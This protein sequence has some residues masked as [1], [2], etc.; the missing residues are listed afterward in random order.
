MAA[1]HSEMGMGSRSCGRQ[2]RSF[3]IVLNVRIRSGKLGGGKIESI[4][5][6]S[7]CQRIKKIEMFKVF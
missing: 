3:V 6:L 7:H 4:Q 1:G 5:I 2:F